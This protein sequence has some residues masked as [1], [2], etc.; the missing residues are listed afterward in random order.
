MA[1]MSKLQQTQEM[2]LKSQE[3]LT[4]SRENW[5]KFLSHACRFYKYDFT[6]QLL[7]YAQKPE[8]SA[9]ATFDQ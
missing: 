4:E 6:S 3:E 7:I 8:A 9:C 1:N 2:L 5:E